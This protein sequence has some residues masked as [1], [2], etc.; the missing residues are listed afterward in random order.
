VRERKGVARPGSNSPLGPRMRY[1]CPESLPRLLSFGEYHGES[2][3]AATLCDTETQL[4][5]GHLRRC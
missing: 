5:T 3:T 1:A 2:E 4:L